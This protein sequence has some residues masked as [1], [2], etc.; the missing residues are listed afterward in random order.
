[1]HRMPNKCAAFGC[2]TGHDTN[3]DQKIASFHFPHARK[4]LLEKWI[5]F[6]NR[7]NWGP[8]TNSS[9]F[10][11]RTVH[12][13]REVM[14]S[15]VEIESCSYSSQQNCLKTSFA[16]KYHTPSQTSKSSQHWTW[17]DAPIQRHVVYDKNEELMIIREKLRN[18]IIQVSSSRKQ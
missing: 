8:S 2:S 17:S 9:L 15:Q 7:L 18:Y 1:M 10:S 14:Y 16:A 4:D 13:L 11:S 12:Q 3:G 6:D 5:K